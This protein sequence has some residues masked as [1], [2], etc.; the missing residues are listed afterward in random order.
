MDIDPACAVCGGSSWDALATKSYVREQIPPDPYNAVRYKILFDLWFPGAA[1]VQLESILCNRCGFMCYRP[2]PESTD[3]DRKYQFIAEHEVSSREFTAE[4]PSDS[5]RS[6]ELYTSLRK[7]LEPGP[8]SIL[9]YGGGNGRLL[10]DFNKKG[11]YCAILELVDETL[12]GINY[13]GASIDDLADHQPFDI[14][15]CSH[16]LEHLADPLST[17]YALVKHI[18]RSGLIYVEVP[19]E[20]WRRPPPSLDPVTHINFF[21]T[22]SL[23]VLMRRAGIAVH[24]VHYATFTRPNGMKGIAVKA[25]GKP[26][27]SVESREIELPGTKLAYSLLKPTLYHRIKR[28]VRHPWLLGNVFL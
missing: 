1:T 23:E 13:V 27:D 17:M 7:Y 5:V 6:R 25:L 28:I 14:L 22:D 11:H 10:G 16:V 24:Y 8:K 18:K 12:P 26:A 2:R 9:D 15:I 4:K 21:T 19:S 3:I 20:I